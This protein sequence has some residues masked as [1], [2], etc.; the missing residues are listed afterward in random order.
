VRSQGDIE[1][2][3]DKSFGSNY[4]LNSIWKVKETAMTCV[5]F[6]NERRP[7][8]GTVLQELREAMKLE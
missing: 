8:M 2:V 7:T 1:N 6:N 3:I 4:Q 5:E